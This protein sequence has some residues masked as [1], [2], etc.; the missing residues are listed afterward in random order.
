MPQIKRLIALVEMP[1]SNGEPQSTVYATLKAAQRSGIETHLIETRGGGFSAQEKFRAEAEEELRTA[2]IKWHS[3]FVSRFTAIPTI[4]NFTKEALKILNP[5]CSFGTP[6]VL[7]FLSYK[8]IPV[9]LILKK[10]KKIP[11]VYSPLAAYWAKRHYYGGLKNTLYGPLI[12]WLEKKGIKES[13]LTRVETPFLG[14]HLVEL[15]RDKSLKNK[16]VTIPNYFEE[17]LLPDKD[18]DREAWRKKLGFVGKKVVI[19]A[20]ALEVWY[21]FPKM[22]DVI[23]ALKKQDPTIFFQ[24]Y[25]KE[26]NARPESA[27]LKNRIKEWAKERGLEEKRD[28]AISLFPACERYYYLSAG[29]IG[30]CLAKPALFKNITLF[31]KITDYWGSFLPIIVNSDVF[32]TAKIIKKYQAGIALSYEDWPV[33]LANLSLK[34]LNS[35]KIDF[36]FRHQYSSSQTSSKYLEIFKNCFRENFGE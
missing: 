30:I 15:H 23:C 34:D 27:G 16:I 33:A 13:Y 7:L 29:D 32:E 8:F 6:T 28:Y 1:L 11:F 25:G 19:Y 36:S 5:L 4:V 17:A 21:D 12:K 2:G 26:D 20:G 9:A 3:I 10:T 14:Q 31:S 22:L 18:W 35:K 24:I